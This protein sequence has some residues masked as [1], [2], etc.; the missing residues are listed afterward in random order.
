[1]Q[2]ILKAKQR[3]PGFEKDKITVIMREARKNH[4]FYAHL[5]FDWLRKI[6]RLVASF[7]A[8]AC[9]LNDISILDALCA[10]M[11]KR[12]GRERELRDKYHLLRHHTGF[13]P[14]GR[15]VYIAR[16]DELLAELNYY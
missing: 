14:K 10:E 2:L 16:C 11:E 15:I 9:Q 12:L 5:Y 8:L 4:T 13:T 6:F 1:V 3:L 7:Y